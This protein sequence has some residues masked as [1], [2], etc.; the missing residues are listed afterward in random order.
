MGNFKDHK[1][2]GAPSMVFVTPA[3]GQ[4]PNQNTTSM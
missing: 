1:E 3:Y 2:L 4:S